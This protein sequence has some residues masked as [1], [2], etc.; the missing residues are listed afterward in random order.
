MIICLLCFIE[1]RVIVETWKTFNQYSQ[2]NKNCVKYIILILSIEIQFPRLSLLGDYCCKNVI[3]AHQYD[4]CKILESVCFKDETMLIKT[5]LNRRNN[6]VV[7][8]LQ[9]LDKSTNLNIL[10][11][12]VIVKVD[13]N[14]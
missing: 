7:T 2:N 11:L 5:V 14:G 9:T 8:A 3:F 1:I 10:K 6:F 13:E 4:F 12:F